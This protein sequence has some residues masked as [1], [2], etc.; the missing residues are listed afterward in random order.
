MFVK[1][2]KTSRM[3]CGRKGKADQGERL[4]ELK[5][6]HVATHSL[7]PQRTGVN[8]AHC[9]TMQLDQFH[10][11]SSGFFE[12][13]E[14]TCRQFPDAGHLRYTPGLMFYKWEFGYFFF[15]NTS[16]VSIALYS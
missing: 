6:T 7:P 15:V 13:E 11:V 2:L 12:W 8:N 3:S 4:R 10:L 1:R 14:Y 16:T 9:L 5:E